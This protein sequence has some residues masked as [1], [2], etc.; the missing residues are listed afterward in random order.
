MIVDVLI[1][2]LSQPILCLAP[3]NQCEQL[4]EDLSCL[5][6]KLL[7][8][9][10][11]LA[12]LASSYLCAILHQWAGSPEIS[13]AQI[14]ECHDLV[15]TKVVLALCGSTIILIVPVDRQQ[16]GSLAI[17]SSS[18]LCTLLIRETRQI[19]L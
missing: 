14:T 16:I 10:V 6:G 2:E 18:L 19:E 5:L 3:L 9:V 4:T 15:D 17:I 8:I 11:C 12:I 13:L 7:I 1:F